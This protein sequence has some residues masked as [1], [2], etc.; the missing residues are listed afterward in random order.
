MLNNDLTFF[1][2]HCTLQYPLTYKKIFF[3]KRRKTFLI[4]SKVT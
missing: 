2:L 1:Q 4:D 3:V